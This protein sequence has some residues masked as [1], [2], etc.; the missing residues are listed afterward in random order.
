MAYIYHLPCE[1]LLEIMI[2]CNSDVLSLVKAFPVTLHVLLENRKLFVTRMLARFGDVDLPSFALA[3]RLR[4]MRQQPGF[5]TLSN[6]MVERHLETLLDQNAEESEPPCFHRFSLAA[7]CVLLEVGEDAK[8]IFDTYQQQLSASA[9]RILGAE[10]TPEELQRVQSL[11][12]LTREERK[13]FMDAAFNYESHCL[14]Y[15]RGNRFL[16]YVSSGRYFNYGGTIRKQFFARHLWMPWSSRMNTFGRF[17][18]IRFYIL[19]KH[20]DLLSIVAKRLESIHGK[21]EL[22]IDWFMQPDERYL[23]YCFQNNDFCQQL[24]EYICFLTSQGLSMLTRLQRISHRCLAEFT[25]TTFIQFTMNRGD[26]RSPWHLERDEW[27]C[28]NS[29]L[30]PRLMNLGQNIWEDM[31]SHEHPLRMANQNMVPY[32]VNS[33]DEEQWE[34]FWFLIRVS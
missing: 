32:R 14:A 22:Q 19:Q 13:L 25:I 8:N 2:Y 33:G 10:L 27:A 20:W 3:G 23:L 1:L 15:Y 5:H 29:T 9:T 34:N 17:Y 6:F 24:K 11:I 7:L 30:P 21:V 12:E 4:H 31:W 26:V 28:L 18:C 16:F